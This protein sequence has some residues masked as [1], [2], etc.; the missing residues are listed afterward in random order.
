MKM[1]FINNNHRINGTDKKLPN[2]TGS[3]SLF[4]ADGATK[5]YFRPAQALRLPGTAQRLINLQ[6]LHNAPLTVKPT[7]YSCR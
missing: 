7:I 1:R 6:P 4:T 5:V 3:P 2:G